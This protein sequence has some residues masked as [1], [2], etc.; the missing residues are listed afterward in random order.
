[1]SDRA[2]S[3]F[4]RMFRA[5]GAATGDPRQPAARNRRTATLCPHPAFHVAGCAKAKAT[6]GRRWCCRD[7]SGPPP[8]GGLARPEPRQGVG[9]TAHRHNRPG[10][11]GD[12]CVSRSHYRASLI[13]HPSNVPVVHPAPLP[14][15]PRAERSGSSAGRIPTVGSSAPARLKRLILAKPR[16][17]CPSVLREA[18]PATC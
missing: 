6:A 10:L 5:A 9:E 17:P 3:F 8:P 16:A 15:W 1:M 12:C 7:R 18:V 13:A 2:T 11:V 4:L 14:L